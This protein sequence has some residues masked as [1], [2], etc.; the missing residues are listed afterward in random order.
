MLE[1]ENSDF[2]MFIASAVEYRFHNVMVKHYTMQKHGVNK[3]FQLYMNY[4][5]YIRKY[6]NF[7]DINL[8]LQ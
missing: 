7:V 3:N 5:S 6:M 2:N 4:I 1:R 8:S